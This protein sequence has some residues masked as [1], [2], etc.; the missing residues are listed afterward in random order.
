MIV[1]YSDRLNDPYLTESLALYTPL[2]IHT[3]NEQNLN[4]RSVGFCD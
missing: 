3:T 2:S 1:T 4:P